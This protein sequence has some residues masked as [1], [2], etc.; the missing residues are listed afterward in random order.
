MSETVGLDVGA[1]VE[2][3]CSGGARVG[4]GFLVGVLGASVATVGA[5]YLVRLELASVV[6]LDVVPFLSGGTWLDL[7]PGHLLLK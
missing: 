2:I 7:L 6:S 1:M 4:I 5:G 3:D